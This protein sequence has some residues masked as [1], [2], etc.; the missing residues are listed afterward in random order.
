M[1]ATEDKPLSE[2]GDD[3]HLPPIEMSWDAAKVLADGI[4][5]PMHLR[6]FGE[7]VSEVLG[8]LASVSIETVEVDDR[9]IPVFVVKFNEQVS[10]VVVSLRDPAGQESGGLISGLRES[11]QLR[12]NYFQG[13]LR[14]FEHCVG[15]GPDA[16]HEKATEPDAA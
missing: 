2:Y 4:Y 10:H 12:V 5:D 14:A 13:R 15:N 9:K 8:Q 1:T 16:D 3:L 6:G 11:L 7:L